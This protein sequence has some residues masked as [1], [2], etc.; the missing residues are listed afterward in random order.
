M[1]IKI[2]IFAFFITLFLLIGLPYSKYLPAPQKEPPPTEQQIVTIPQII[3]KAAVIQSLQSKAQIVGLS[4]N[5][6]KEFTYQDTNFLGK[7]KYT[8]RANIHFKLGYNVDELL[9]KLIIH[10]NLITIKQPQIVII[11]SDIPLDEIVIIDD[12]GW[13]RTD[14][15]IADQQA[16]YKIIREK[17]MDDLVRNVSIYNTARVKTNEVVEKIFYV[18]PNVRKVEWIND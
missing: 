4:G 12:V 8:Y 15:T 1:K 7:R 10:S 9:N 17:A 11:A 5:S 3:N 18:I 14:L 13:L 6:I 2:I 16:I